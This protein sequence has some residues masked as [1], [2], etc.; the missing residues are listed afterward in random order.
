MTRED[1]NLWW[2]IDKIISSFCIA[3][4]LKVNKS[5]SIVL[6]VGLSSNDVSPYK[7]LLPYSFRELSVGFKCMGY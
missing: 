6:H 4:G 3:Y 2:E 1:L 7:D 5:K